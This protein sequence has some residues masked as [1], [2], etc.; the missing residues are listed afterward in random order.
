[1]PPPDHIQFTV[2]F[3]TDQGFLGRACNNSD[4]KRYFKIHKDSIKPQMYCPYCGVAFPNDQLWTD[5]QLSY[6]KEVAADVIMPLVQKQL[7]DMLSRTLRHSK[8]VTFE[9]ARP[10]RRPEPRA[11][12]EHE[13][14]SE[15]MCP[16]CETQFQVDGIFGYCPGCRAENLRLY[17]ANLEI[18]RREVTVSNNPDRAL[19]HA[20]NDL[21]STFEAFCRKEAQRRAIGTARFQNIDHTRQLFRDHCGIDILAGLTT[22]QIRQLKRVFEKRH[23]GEHTE[24][25]VSERYVQQIPEDKGC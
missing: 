16:E 24:G 9:P 23:V 7:S 1:V 3:P 21:V 19:R 20:Y 11:P 13:V 18:I 12:T 4:C 25:I 15:L 22:Q 14:D 8:H 5:D 17:D 6:A 2:S 10:A